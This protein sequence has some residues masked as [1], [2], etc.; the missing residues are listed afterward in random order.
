MSAVTTV[1]SENINSFLNEHPIVLLGF[2][3]AWCGPCKMM[4]PILFDLASQH[5]GEYAV[6]KINVDECKEIAEQYEIEN[7]PTL[8]VIKHGKEAG[9][10]IG[11]LGMEE[12]KKEIV[13][14]LF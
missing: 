8:L 10:I 9:R 3:A 13:N 12:L 1:D 11:Y 2:W 7:L 14:C 5:K 6:G 4:S